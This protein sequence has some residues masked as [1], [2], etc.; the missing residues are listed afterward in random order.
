LAADELVGFVQRHAPDAHARVLEVGPGRGELAAGLLAVGY[1]MTAVDRDPTAVVATRAKR[2]PAYEVDF[3]E[4]AGGP[5]DI[6]VFSRTLHEIGDVSSALARVE[7]VLAPGGILIVD[8][9]ARDW[10]DRA[11]AA[12][13]YDV[14]YLLGAT[15]LLTPPAGPEHE[16]PLTRWERE[17]GKQRENPRPGADE[18][19]DNVQQRFDILATEE[20]AYLYRHIGQWVRD[21]D[22]GSTVLQRLHEIEVRRIARGELRPIGL[23]LSA[24][25]R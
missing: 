3:L 15:G 19:L 21:D 14:C 4:Y 1:Q 13:F 8:E 18:I 17:Y 12:L 7:Q 5:H 24:R 25:R 22:A 23:R 16:D 9:F 10:M 6:V 2:V 20:H 11:T